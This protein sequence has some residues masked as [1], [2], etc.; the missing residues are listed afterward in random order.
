LDRLFCGFVTWSFFSGLFVWA[1]TANYNRLLG[2]WR[3]IEVPL[4]AGSL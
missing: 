3:R 1:I 4:L 2:Y